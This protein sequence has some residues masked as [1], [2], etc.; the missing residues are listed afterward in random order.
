MLRLRDD[1]A[2]GAREVDTQVPLRRLGRADEVAE[3]ICF[4]LSDTASYVTGTVLP[5]DGGLSIL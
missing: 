3:V 1:P 5:V 4:L 2:R